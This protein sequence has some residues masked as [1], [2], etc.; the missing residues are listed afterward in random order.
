MCGFFRLFGEND[1][2][3]RMLKDFMK[4]TNKSND[5]E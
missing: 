3:H 2:V 5:L 4:K 1:E